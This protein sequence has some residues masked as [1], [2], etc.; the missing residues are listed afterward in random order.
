M[1]RPPKTRREHEVAGTF[2]RDRHSHRNPDPP[3]GIPTS[4][5]ELTGAALD[6]WQRMI[7]RLSKSGS[8]S[9]V[10][11]AALY[12][13]CRLFAETE[14]IEQTQAE[15]AAS[16]EILEQNLAGLEGAELV[17]CFQ[18]ITKLR[19]LEARYTTQVRQG[20][21]ALRTFLVEFG[22]TPAARGRVK[23]FDKPAETDAFTAFQ[24]QRPRSK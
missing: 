9:V 19:Q 11:D 21:M 24:K 12:Q 22:L 17:Q 18:E 2:R 10:D 1:A 8:L 4:P 23:L 5:K 3:K 6:E 7:D 16:I 13:Y 15:T 20:R 14:A